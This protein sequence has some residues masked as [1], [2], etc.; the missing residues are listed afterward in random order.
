MRGLI[1]GLAIATLLLTAAGVTAQP[2]AVLGDASQ[3]ALRQLD[4]FRHDDFDAAYGFASSDM[5]KA[6][7]CPGS[8]WPRTA[9]IPS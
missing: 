5:G 6:K 7:A 8:P 2:A 9:R 3:V 1:R 4:A